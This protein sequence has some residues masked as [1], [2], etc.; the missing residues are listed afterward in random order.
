MDA[1]SSHRVGVKNVVA[2]SGTALTKDHLVL[3]QRYT[4]NLI[5]AFDVDIAGA[6][7]TKRG[8]D[9]ALAAGF[10]VKVAKMP[11]KVDPDDLCRQDPQA[12]AKAINQCEPIVDYYIRRSSEGKDLSRVENKKAVA[13]EVLPEVARLTDPVEQ[14]HYLQRLEKILGVKE[15]ILRQAVERSRVTG[16]RRDS[17]QKRN[18]AQNINSKQ[19]TNKSQVVDQ[20]TKRLARLIALCVRT[21][22][23]DRSRVKALEILADQKILAVIKILTETPR[24]LE[25]VDKIQTA[26]KD[27]GLLVDRE[28]FVLEQ[29]ETGR[30]EKDA[31]VD[32]INELKQLVSLIASEGLRRELS[33]LHTQAARAQGS[34]AEKLQGIFVQ[35]T[36]RLAEFVRQEEI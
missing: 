29:E 33:A 1:I 20:I 4:Q 24:I 23:L 26:D 22:G 10:N 35:K 19:A 30:D 36:Q 5:L 9:L 16:T 17:G 6:N 8:I 2:T 21:V 11:A 31:E 34:D 27:L 15:D 32:A 14:T 28:L 7:A 13:R 12:W 18:Q 25:I 3:L